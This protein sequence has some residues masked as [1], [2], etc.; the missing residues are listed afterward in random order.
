MKKSQKGQKFSKNN[1]FKFLKMSFLLM[2]IV[3]FAMQVQLFFSLYMEN[4]TILGINYQ[5]MPSKAYPSITLCPENVLK[6]T[7]VALSRQDF[8]QLSNKVVLI[9]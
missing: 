3:F 1:I 7:G 2:C 4:A 8:D 6:G 5:K 9:F